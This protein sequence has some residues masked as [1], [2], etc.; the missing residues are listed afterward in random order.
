MKRV[1]AVVTEYRVRSHADNIVTRLLEGYELHWTTVRPSVQVA[2]LYT[3]QVPAADISRDLAATH[4]V[5]IYATIGEALT[6]GGAALAVDGVV[7][8]G[9]HGDYPLNARGQKQYPRRRFFA[10]TAAVFR[11]SGRAV[12]VFSDKHLAAAWAD[13][14]WIYDTARALG[15]PLMAGSS[16][17]VT[18]RVRRWRSPTAP[19]SRRSSSSPTAGWRATAS[20]LWRWP[21]A[22]PSGA[23]G[24]RRGC[25]RCSASPAMPSGP[26]CSGRTAG[27][28]TW[29]TRP[30]PPQP[31][32]RGRCATTTPG[33]TTP[34]SAPPASNSATTDPDREPREPALFRL[35]YRDGLRATVL[36]LN[37]YVTQRGAAVRVADEAE[38]LATCFTQARRQPVWHFDHQVD[39]IERMVLTGRPPYPVERTLL[40]TGATEA[41]M[42]SRHEGGRVV[43]TP[44]LAIAYAPEPRRPTTRAASSP[45]AGRAAGCSSAEHQSK[46]REQRQREPGEQRQRD[47]KRRTQELRPLDARCPR[48]TFMRGH[49]RGPANT[50]PRTAAVSTPA[51]S[52]PA[53]PG[54]CRP[55]LS[56]ASVWRVLDSLLTRCRG[57]AR[58]S[59]Q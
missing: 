46:L 14:K 58:R 41:V 44:H 15:V 4:G 28:V 25:A 56:P 50:S 37:G 7:L 45:P 5:P 11:A 49:G 38:P 23:A 35:V 34:A 20:T 16:M 43:E 27:R 33:C 57:L 3:D 2:S 42:I 18:A 9:E 21:S 8:V 59:S 10:E 22:S 26:P 51:S 31:T 55:R 40:T 6:L 36:M 24:T 48:S 19:P 47:P 39:L 29:R 12:P 32:P 13:A 17:P 53:L 54:C 1:A 52:E 30:W